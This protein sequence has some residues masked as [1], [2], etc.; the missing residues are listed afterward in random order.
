MTITQY[1][2]ALLISIG[3]FV[4]F[5]GCEKSGIEQ[6]GNNPDNNIDTTDIDVLRSLPYTGGFATDEDE[7]GGVVFCDPQRSC[8]GYNLYGVHRFSMAEL[9]D[10]EGNVINSWSLTPRHTWERAELLPNGDLLAIGIEMSLKPGRRRLGSIPDDVRYVMRLNWEGQVLW[11]QKLR[12]HH[13]IEVAPSGKLLLLTFQRRIVHNL[14]PTVDTREDQLTLL[15]QDGTVIESRSILQAVSRHPEIFPLQRVKP[16]TNT[17]PPSLDVF[18]S[19]SVE[20]MYQQHLVGKH[21]IYDLDNILVCFRHQDRVAVFNWTRNEVVWAWG[22]GQLIGPHDAQILENGHMLLFDNGI[23]RGYS[24][25]IEL[26]PLTKKIVWKYQADPP[27]SFY[28][29]SRGSVQ[30][31]PNGNTLMAESDK[32]R[33]VEVTPSGEIVW[34]FICPHKNEQGERATIVR[35]NRFPREYI[36]AI[37]KQHDG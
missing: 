8:P 26:D 21:P 19:N 37:I 7:V 12:A 36:E 24:R 34:E 4:A 14:H 30:R 11:K 15:E 31:L 16:N 18:H 9:I 22:R 1:K 28:T 20:W 17:R 25:A 32:G 6:G 10:E 29:I 23:G 27:T 3:L 5:S 13:D 33:A 2:P 35:M